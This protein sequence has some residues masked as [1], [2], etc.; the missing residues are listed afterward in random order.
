[1]GEN[2]HQHQPGCLR[3]QAFL[4]QHHPDR[5]H[6]PSHRLGLRRRGC[7]KLQCRRCWAGSV[8]RSM[9]RRCCLSRRFEHHW[10]V[11]GHP[12][13]RRRARPGACHA[14][15][16]TSFRRCFLQ[17]RRSRASCRCRRCRSRRCRS[18][19]RR[20]W[21]GRP[22]A[23]PGRSYH[24]SFPSYQQLGGC[25]SDRGPLLQR[26]QRRR[27]GRRDVRA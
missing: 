12:Q 6:S 22:P 3:R 8:R 21:R 24:S 10:Y 27:L 26:K 9:R 2:H 23:W 1:M 13:P 16:R 14:G 25:C 15:A 19:N 18:R 4:S 5:L 11:L 17:P 7:R 20:A